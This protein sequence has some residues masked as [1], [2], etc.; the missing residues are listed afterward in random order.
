MIKDFGFFNVVTCLLYIQTIFES[1]V[2]KLNNQTECIALARKN[3]CLNSI[4]V[5]SKAYGNLMETEFK[6]YLSRLIGP[7]LNNT[8]NVQLE[9]I[10]SG[11]MFEILERGIG[12]KI[13]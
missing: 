9:F 8:Q 10:I 2:I 12:Q 1:N 7:T 6:I 4:Y 13:F 3:L 11:S 5:Q